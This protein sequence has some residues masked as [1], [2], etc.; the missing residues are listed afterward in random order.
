MIEILTACATSLT[1]KYLTWLDGL[2]ACL[3]S[4]QQTQCPE[5]FQGR[6]VVIPESQVSL[7]LSGQIPV[8]PQPG[9]AQELE[10]L[11]AAA[12]ESGEPLA[13][14]MC[15]LK[16]E[17]VERLALL[18][19]AAPEINRKYERVFAYLQDDVAQRRATLGLCGDL[20]SLVEAVDE[21]ALFALNDRGRLWDRCILEGEGSG[22]ARVLLLRDGV[23]SWLTREAGLPGVLTGM[24]QYVPADAIPESPMDRELA[25]R[26]ARFA[27][28]C[29]EKDGGTG[30]LALY[31]PEGS[32]RRSL[33]RFAVGQAERP[34]L[35]LDCQRLMALPAG[36]RR[37]AAESALS[38][39]F[40]RQT[41]PCLYHFDFEEFQPAERV[42]LGWELLDVFRGAVPLLGLCGE[43]PLSQWQGEGIQLLPISLPF[44][45][46]G[47]QR[48][49][50]ELFL[51]KG[52]L[53]PEEGLDL[54]RLAG[55][56]S[57][58][59]GQ[60]RR[61]LELAETDCLSRGK[62]RMDRQSIAHGVRLL[63]S[64][65][66]RELAQPLT[67]SFTWDDLEVGA[68]AREQLKRLCQRVRRRWQV[69]EEWGFDRK[70]PYGKGLSVCLYG[71]PGTGKTMTA[72]VLAREFGLDAYRVDL[73]CIMDKYIGETEK[74]LGELFDAARGSNAILFF[75]EAD[76]LFSKRTE[77]SDSK[78]R[79][80]NAETA[81]LL[82]RM[83]AHNGISILAT[84]AVQNFDE[85]FKRRISYM[86]S[87]PMP[88]AETRKRLWRKVFPPQAPL[89][90]DCLDFF[91]QRFELSG[92][93]IKN[94]ALTAAYLAASGSG[95][96]GREELAEAVREEYRKTGRVLM[97]HELY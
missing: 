43:K 80:A 48:R 69:N 44:P 18:L 92:S 6:G 25:E 4:I 46:I 42:R 20:W 61:V 51:Q 57:L 71:P 28:L 47:Q 3:L 29:L 24:A 1:E 13:V 86:I 74:K 63:C 33:L 76:A 97:E 45:S 96:I 36:E 19:A 93:A 62:D 37:A 53:P 56:Y 82:Q 12:E 10:A 75:D 26:T 23:R 5:A 8:E 81:Y 72:Q 27:R 30:V 73:S 49:C 89:D 95:T 34:A 67:L 14:L 91:A 65:R 11:N 16:A 32:G 68:D 40:A 7:A 84:N 90:Q 35:L 31:G 66:L 58:T 78:D 41:V 9:F 87:L 64:A 17:G 85:A 38:W 88:D 52:T 59:P 21:E 50:W 79:Y 94:V 2:C 70:F 55:V 54:D 22:L 39:C 83:E 60:I 15:R 77:V